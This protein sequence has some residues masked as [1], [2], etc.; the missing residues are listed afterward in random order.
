MLCSVSIPLTDGTLFG[1][2]DWFPSGLR[3]GLN[4]LTDGHPLRT[5][6]PKVDYHVEEYVVS[7][8]H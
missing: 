5:K 4:T 7:I 1:Q 2:Q 8:P 3:A 6:K